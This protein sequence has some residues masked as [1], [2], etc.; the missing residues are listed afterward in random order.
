[1]KRH[2]VVIPA[3]A[4]A[5]LAACSPGYVY[6][7]D[8]L[9]DSTQAQRTFVHEVRSDPEFGSSLEEV[10]DEALVDAGYLHCEYLARAAMY[11]G[12]VDAALLEVMMDYPEFD[13]SRTMFLIENANS[14]LCGW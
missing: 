2:H 7:G 1:M 10:P 14:Y 12:G 5:A 6:P 9:Y 4:C 11:G 3:L 13:P 8:S